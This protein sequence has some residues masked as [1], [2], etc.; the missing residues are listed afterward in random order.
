ME[1]L[2]L[3]NGVVLDCPYNAAIDP[4]Y[5]PKPHVSG[6]WLR[7]ELEA[8]T[9]RPL[10]SKGPVNLGPIGNSVVKDTI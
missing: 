3:P 5:A 1:L 9:H 4:K 7:E 8:K 2:K 10:T 6:S